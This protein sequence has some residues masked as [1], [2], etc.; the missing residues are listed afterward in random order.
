MFIYYL[1]NKLKYYY[2]NNNMTGPWHNYMEKLFPKEMQEITFKCSSKNSKKERR[3]DVILS[4]THSLEFQHSYINQKE[5]SNRLNDWKKFGKDIIW[6]IDG[7]DGIVLDKLS[8]NNTLMIFK[9][10]WKYNSF[11]DYNYILLEN[12]KLIYKIKISSVKSG[13]IE[14]KEAKSLE[15]TIDFLKSKP[16][17][18][19]D[20]WKDDNDVKSK[21]GVYQQGA[22]NGKTY[23]IWKSICENVDKKTY[24]IVTKQHSAKTVI[25][26]E[27]K[28][29]HDRF[30]DDADEAVFH[31]EYI[32]D[33]TEENTE[34]QYVI[35]YTHKQ[36]K[37]ECIV[38]IG[39]I[40]SFCY[41]LSD[42][43]SK[44]TDFFKGIIDN[45][46]V[47]GPTKSRNGYFRYA[48]LYIQLSKE[49]EVWIDEVQD[50]PEN[51]L[52]AMLK[53]MYETSCHVNV[54]GDKLQS[55]EFTN[56]FLT[57]VVKEGLPNIEVYTPKPTNINRRIKVTNMGDEI[58]K[59]IYF[60]DYNLPTIQ[61]DEEVNKEINEEPITLIESPEIYANDKDT[62]KV[63]NFCNKIMKE[64][65]SEVEKNNYLPNDFL[66]VFPIMK[67]NIIAPQLQTKI[68]E[69]WIKKNNDNN[70]NYT[71]Y[72]FLHKHTEG[73][74]INTT[75]SIE[76]TRIMSIRSSKG[77]GR[78]VVFILG[79]TERTLKIVSNNKE[80]GLVYESQL[81]VALTRA[82]KQI[83]VG[84][85]KNNDEIHQRF[86]K[87]GYVEYLP[88]ISK[89][90]HLENMNELINKDNLI[91]ILN[92]NGIKYENL[93]KDICKLKQL[94]PVDW[95]YHCI[96][97][98][99]YYYQVIL[100]IINKHKGNFDNTQ[101][102]VTLTIISKYRLEDV[103][104]KDYYD[105]LREYQYKTD[106]EL[107]YFP[108][109]KLSN[110]H[111]YN[112]YFNRI[113]DAIKKIQVK[114]K[115]KKMHE[116]NVYESII[117]TYMI[118]IK[119]SQLY[120]DMSPVDIY[121]I[122]D[123]FYKNE[124]KES[125]LLHN[126]SNIHAIIE[127]SNFNNYKN[128][129]WNIFKHIELFSNY[130]YFKISNL[131]YPIIGNNKTDVIHIV[132]K[133]NLSK[134]NF[135]DIMIEILLER[136]LIYNP[137]SKEDK[138]KF[139]NKTITTHLFLL[140]ENRF[141]KINWDWDKKY[142]NIIKMEISKTLKKFYECN[143]RDIYKYLK[144]IKS[145]NEL[146]DEEPAKIIDEIINKMKH[147]PNYIIKVFDDINT[148]IEEEE[149]TSYI[150]NFDSFNDKLNKKLSIQLNKYLQI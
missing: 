65:K 7:N 43:N 88:S 125:E 144:D 19:W 115:V 118:Q 94:K 38:I 83:Y 23:G 136:F 127:K 70:D 68:Q 52:H 37:R 50:L 80:I 8:T 99:T 84:L 6:L 97:H 76:A 90:I 11:K 34:N 12:N 66:I 36:S 104:V 108:I 72:V 113:K 58:N 128:I 147:F 32:E 120:A 31:I 89:K 47:N 111:E 103:N 61:C 121:N 18:I 30:K 48:G 41:N 81:H 102:F 112:K 110:K 39:T 63:N 135:W 100:N 101:L 44:G 60:E 16:E 145:N 96:K 131:Q 29:Q 132:L 142:C 14:L 4:N 3:A 13:M 86:A 93:E 91:E 141:L 134:L 2:N 64:Y 26:E 55:L 148:K 123:I 20:F 22:G 78:K 62:E 82:E 85:I 17:N 53:I 69:F 15:E 54:V 92:N 149:D 33:K 56:N 106:K 79:V 67:S 27:L 57:D 74:V 10:K 77:D 117:L 133:N 51:Y 124:N 105:Y 73:K 87:T 40:D 107:P 150:E 71:Q 59:L 126:I 25:Y 139:E 119:T 95:G 21:L 5:V 137:K 143:H 140:D 28:K 24:I 130:D 9:D 49:C 98:S 75:D 138:D 1:I 122:T 46:K 114:I 129:T 116:L 42:S 35:K 109:C 146:W 45:I